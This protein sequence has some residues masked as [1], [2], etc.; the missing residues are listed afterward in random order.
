MGLFQRRNIT[1]LWYS[2]PNSATLIGAADNHCDCD[3]VSK[4]HDA[5]GQ[6]CVLSASPVADCLAPLADCL[7]RIRRGVLIAASCTRLEYLKN[8][9]PLTKEGNLSGH[10]VLHPH[11]RRH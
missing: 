2:C 6:G 3:R 7:S 9:L 10:H 4:G 11:H 5:K 1:D 8:M